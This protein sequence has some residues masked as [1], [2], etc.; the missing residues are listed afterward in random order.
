MCS[1]CIDKFQEE[2]ASPPISEEEVQKLKKF[3]AQPPERLAVIVDDLEADC[4]VE[5]GHREKVLEHYDDWMDACAGPNDDFVVIEGA[6]ARDLVEVFRLP[7]DL[8][9]PIGSSTLAN[10][11]AAAEASGFQFHVCGPSTSPC[12][13]NRDDHTW[14]DDVEFY[15]AGR[16]VGGSVSCS[17]CGLTAMDYDIWNAP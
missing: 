16:V 9:G 4:P 14:D 15:A 1:A 17:K 13:P 10:A 2:T 3:F 8:L 6:A 5:P 12:G 7:P 11:R